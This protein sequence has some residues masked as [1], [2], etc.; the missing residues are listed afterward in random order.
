MTVGLQSLSKLVGFSE[1]H[2]VII[3]EKIEAGAWFY[4][5]V[6]Q[7]KDIEPRITHTLKYAPGVAKVD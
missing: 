2:Q 5:F 4:I 3:D 7:I 6:D 1:Q